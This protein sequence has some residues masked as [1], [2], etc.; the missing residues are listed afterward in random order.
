[1]KLRSSVK[2]ADDVEHFLR[3]TLL[4]PSE[5]IKVLRNGEATRKGILTAVESFCAP[6]PNT[7]KEGS[8]ILIYFSGHG[9]RTLVSKKCRAHDPQ[10]EDGKIEA[11]CPVDFNTLDEDGKI[12]KGIPDIML[13]SMVQKISEVVKTDN[14]VS[15]SV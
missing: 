8:T 12:I 7:I 10:S 15:I 1:M 6:A 9:T 4:V 5:R 14:I 3:T 11:I 2:D 13:K